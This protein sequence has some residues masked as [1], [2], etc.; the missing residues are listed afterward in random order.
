M[1]GMRILVIE[2]EATLGQLVETGLRPRSFRAGADGHQAARRRRRREKAGPDGPTG[3][4]IER[5]R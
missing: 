1:A 2:D 3:S 4:I 5:R